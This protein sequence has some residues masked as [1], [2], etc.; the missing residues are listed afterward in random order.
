V[1]LLELLVFVAVGH[2]LVDQRGASKTGREER[3]GQDVV[4]RGRIYLHAIIMNDFCE[5]FHYI[6]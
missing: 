3:L 1:L 2:G 6:D 4:V 5:L